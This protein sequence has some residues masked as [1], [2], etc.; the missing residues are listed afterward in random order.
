MKTFSEAQ[1]LERIEWLKKQN[2]KNTAEMLGLQNF[3][4]CQELIE[5]YKP[6]PKDQLLRAEKLWESMKQEKKEEPIEPAVPITA[7]MRFIEWF[8]NRF[9]TDRGGERR[10]VA[11]FI[12]DNYRSGAVYLLKEFRARRWVGP[13]TPLRDVPRIIESLEELKKRDYL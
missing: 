6:I 2:E 10:Q 1:I 4:R 7:R 12:F 5:S 13:R 3:L 11:C 8:L 9:K